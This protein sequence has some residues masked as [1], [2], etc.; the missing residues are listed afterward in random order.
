MI[1]APT[2]C[3]YPEINGVFQP[4]RASE[5]RRKNESKSR[6]LIHELKPNSDIADNENL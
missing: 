6:I 2:P 3:Q 4:C 5:L 1:D